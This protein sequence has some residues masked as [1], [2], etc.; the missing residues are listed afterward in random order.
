VIVDSG[1]IRAS[2]KPSTPKPVEQ[3]NNQRK[4]SQDANNVQK[5][6]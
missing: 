4:E 3:T 5:R 2:W 1:L 6:S